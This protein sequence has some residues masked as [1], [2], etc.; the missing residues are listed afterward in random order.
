MTAEIK[1]LQ[2][3][4]QTS[5]VEYTGGF[6]IRTYVTESPTF[7]KHGAEVL[8]PHPL[9]VGPKRTFKGFDFTQLHRTPSPNSGSA[10]GANSQAYDWLKAFAQSDPVLTEVPV[11]IDPKSVPQPPPD[12]DAV[13]APL[14]AEFKRIC[15]VI[16]D[17]AVPRTRKLQA[18]ADLRAEAM[19]ATRK[20][21]KWLV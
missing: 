15:R 19:V 21:E 1:E 5:W 16:R 3:T 6:V 4:R 17:P 8:H 14:E 13:L 7:Q 10:H 18:L 2:K 12:P 20:V 9:L 11:P